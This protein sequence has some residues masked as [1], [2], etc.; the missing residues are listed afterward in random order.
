[1]TDQWESRDEKLLR[2]MKIPPKKKMEWLKEMNE[3]LDRLSTRRLRRI[4]Q[5][6]REER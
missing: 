4:R 3:S 2:Y 5:K 6:I 1:M